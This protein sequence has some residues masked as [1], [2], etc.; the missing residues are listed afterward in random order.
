MASKKRKAPRRIEWSKSRPQRPDHDPML[1][2]L[3]QLL[4]KDKRSYHAKADL[5]GLAPSTLKNIED[6]TTRRPQGVTIQMAYAMLGY[7]LKAVKE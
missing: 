7:K 1:A 6:G 5:S 4:I 3:R 2:D